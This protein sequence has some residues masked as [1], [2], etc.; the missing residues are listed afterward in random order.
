M[1]DN[2][3]LNAWLKFNGVSN[4]VVFATWH[5]ILGSCLIIYCILSLLSSCFNTSISIRFYLVFISF[6]FLSNVQLQKRSINKKSEKSKQ[7]YHFLESYFL[8]NLSRNYVLLVYCMLQNCCCPQSRSFLL[9]LY[10]YTPIMHEN[11]NKIVQP[12]TINEN[13]IS[14]LSLLWLLQK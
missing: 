3:Y 5:L 2:L 10:L 9:L 13:K 1:T 7:Q 4:I 6:E 11:G 14:K 8:V 12:I